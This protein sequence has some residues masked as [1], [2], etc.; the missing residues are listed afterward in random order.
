[1]AELV[2]VIE[3]PRFVV[4]LSLGEIALIVDR[5]QGLHN[6]GWSAD[7]PTLAHELE[8]FIES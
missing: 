5:L 7:A 4:N 8:G 1:M 3:E 2:K 6:S